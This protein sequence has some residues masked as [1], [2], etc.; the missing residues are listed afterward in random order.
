VSYR[1]NVHLSDK[2]YLSVRQ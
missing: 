1:G 2:Y